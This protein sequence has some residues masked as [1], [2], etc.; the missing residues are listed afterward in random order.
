[1]N[2]RVLGSLVAIVGAALL[3]GSL[4][5]GW[6]NFQY[7]GSYPASSSHGAVQFVGVSI[8]LPGSSYRT[9]VSCTGD[10]SLCSSFGNPNLTGIH[11]YAN[12]GPGFFAYPNTGRLYEAVQLLVIAAGGL[13]LA[14]AAAV[15][16]SRSRRRS[17]G[18]VG[19]ALLVLAAG[20]GAAAPAAVW[21]ETSATTH[22]DYLADSSMLP[23][24][25][26]GPSGSFWGSCSSPSCGSGGGVTDSWGPAVGWYLAWAGFVGLVAG[27]LLIGWR[28]DTPGTPSR[29]A[30]QVVG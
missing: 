22:A 21:L 27:L 29:A 17:M 24:N 26:T 15:L 20:L 23:P 19:L 8:F 13:A 6:Y 4:F 30:A 5:L 7:A 25:F 10:P 12:P 3:L 28:R 14:G 11:T 2:R 16:L 9:T 18:A 1:M